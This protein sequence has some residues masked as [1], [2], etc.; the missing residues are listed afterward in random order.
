MIVMLGKYARASSENMHISNCAAHVRA[1]KLLQP[2]VAKVQPHISTCVNHTAK[3]AL[4][5]SEIYLCASFLIRLL[6]K[7]CELSFGTTL[8]V[9]YIAVGIYYM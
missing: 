1:R 3:C 8:I 9:A 5:L 2:K 6:R 4:L 7:K